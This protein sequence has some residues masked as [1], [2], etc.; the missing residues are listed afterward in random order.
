MEIFGEL[1][2]LKRQLAS[3]QGIEA[4]IDAAE[5]IL[6]A[7]EPTDGDA[8]PGLPSAG[9]R[10]AADEDDEDVTDGLDLAEIAAVQA[11]LDRELEGESP[12]HP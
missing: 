1:E 7:T 12:F 11:N 8:P 9:A 10:A 5:A 4:D 2:S 6:E 3:L